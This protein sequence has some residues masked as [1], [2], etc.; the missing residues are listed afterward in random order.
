MTLENKKY[1]ILIVDD[2]TKIRNLLAKFLENSGFFIT[3]AQDTEEAR[4]QISNFVF[5]IIVLDVMMPNETGV[6]FAQ[7]LRKS[8]DETPIIMLTALGEVEDKIEGL[9]SGADDYLPKP[10]SPKE[11]LL[12][13]N[14]IIKRTQKQKQLQNI[15]KFGEFKFDLEKLKLKKED[16]SIYLTDT[17]A[18]ILATFCKNINAVMSREDISE[19]SDE[20]DERSV[21]VQ[22][23]RL[24]KKIENSPRNP[25]FL[26]TIRGKGYILKS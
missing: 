11:L 9:E 10:F 19:L 22:I 17:E 6:E 14:S 8:K 21:D 3:T 7:K 23:T 12:R 5:D 25:E 16:D 15:C 1:H 24:R 20:I 18:K 2:D 4:L 26:Q 13:I